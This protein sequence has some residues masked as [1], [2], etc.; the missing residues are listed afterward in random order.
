M[1]KDLIGSGIIVVAA[2]PAAGGGAT[3]PGPA[4]GRVTKRRNMLQLFQRPRCR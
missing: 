1:T 4:T 3:P 2:A